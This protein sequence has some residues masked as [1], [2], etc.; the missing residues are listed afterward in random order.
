MVHEA[1]LENATVADN[2]REVRY[3]GTA[4]LELG[5]VS[6]EHVRIVFGPHYFLEISNDKE[7][8]QF[9]LGASI[10]RAGTRCVLARD[11][12]GCEFKYLENP[13]Q[14][15][16]AS[17]TGATRLSKNVQSASCATLFPTDKHRD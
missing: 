12:D 3:A 10:S 11:I 17:A 5:T 6:T 9:V 8:V 1:L 14:F 15:L 7:K 16:H 13:K 2:P 4:D